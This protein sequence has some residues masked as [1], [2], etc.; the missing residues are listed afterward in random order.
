MTHLS[1]DE[2]RHVARLSRLAFSDAELD[3][4]AEELNGI[5]AYFDKLNELD[6]SETPPTSHALKME[7]VF[8][9]DEVQPSLSV[10]DA[11]ANAPER[12]G[13][14]FKAPRIIQDDD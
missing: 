7:N 2:I 14:F 3:K 11:L 4:F 9:E 10:E 13:D 1:R 5:L 8:R 6:T 12:E